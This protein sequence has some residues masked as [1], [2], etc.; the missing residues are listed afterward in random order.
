MSVTVPGRYLT[1]IF[2]SFRPDFRV[3]L[4]KWEFVIDDGKNVLGDGT[5]SPSLTCPAKKITVDLQC[6]TRW[7][8]LGT[9]VGLLFP[10]SLS[11]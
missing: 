1:N 7:S 9:A 4:D 5:G 11:H 8:K 6:E 2:Q 3:G 10:D